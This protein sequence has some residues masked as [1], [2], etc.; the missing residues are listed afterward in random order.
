MKF[1]VNPAT[2]LPLRRIILLSLCLGGVGAITLALVNL[3]LPLIGSSLSMSLQYE[4]LTVLYLFIGGIL[5]VFVY[6]VW[7]SASCL[8][9][10]DVWIVALLATLGSDVVQSAFCMVVSGPS[11]ATPA[12][13]V[14]AACTSSYRR[15]VTYGSIF[16]VVLITFGVWIA[17]R[18]ITWQVQKNRAS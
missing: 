3:S 14:L 5:A 2:Q 16:A 10:V 18:Y 6:R 8:A 17:V 11:S 9:D 4:I 1:G 15:T 13:S 7:G 12:S